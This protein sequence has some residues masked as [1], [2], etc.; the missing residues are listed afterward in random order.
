MPSDEAPWPEAACRCPCCNVDDSK[1]EPHPVRKNERPAKARKKK[2]QAVNKDRTSQFLA[3]VCN[4]KRSQACI[5]SQVPTQIADRA[6][7]YETLWVTH[8]APPGL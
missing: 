6:W 1:S 7:G 3:M 4:K 5:P 2:G 8:T